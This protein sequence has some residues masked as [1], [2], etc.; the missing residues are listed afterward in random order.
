MASPAAYSQH[1]S[2]HVL[3]AEVLA[4]QTNQALYLARPDEAID[5][6]RAAQAAA[7]RRGSTA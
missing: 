2:D 6:A 1:A 4:G 5:L 7:V 3:A